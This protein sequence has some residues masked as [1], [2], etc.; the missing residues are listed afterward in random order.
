[1]AHTCASHPCPICFPQLFPQPHFHYTPPGCVC[2]P[3]SEQTC[4][5]DYCPRRGSFQPNYDKRL[6]TEKEKRA[7]DAALEGEP[8]QPV[9]DLWKALRF[10]GGMPDLN[11]AHVRAMAL[12]LKRARSGEQ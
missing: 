8:R 4:Q 10:A 3:T 5:A 1:M 11:E 12:A 7:I 6:P 2:P 9:L